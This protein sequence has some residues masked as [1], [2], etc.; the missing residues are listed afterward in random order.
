MQALYKE[1]QGRALSAGRCKVSA[2]AKFD[3]KAA[4]EQLSLYRPRILAVAEHLDRD[5]ESDIVWALR[6]LEAA[7][8]HIEALEGELADQSRAIKDERHLSGNRMSVIDEQDEQLRVYEKRIKELEAV[9]ADHN[10]NCNPP[11]EP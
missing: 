7:L 8:A 2:P 6:T 10:E 3:A 5:W 11:E 1:S 4:R 9:V